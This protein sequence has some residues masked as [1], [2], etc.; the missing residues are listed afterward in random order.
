MNGRHWL[1]G[2]GVVLALLAGPLSAETAPARK[3]DNLISDQ[4]GDWR[5]RHVFDR[6]TLAHRYSDAKTEIRLDEGKTHPFQFNRRGVDGA[7][8]FEIP[9]WFD[10]VVIEADGQTF[11]ETQRGFH[12]FYGT[13]T[14]ELLAAV[15]RA[16][17]PIRITLRH[18]EQVYRGEIPARGSSAAL[19]WIRA[20]Q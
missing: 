1:A 18:G 6:E 5:V 2:W 10:E 7:L 15:A 4:F 11:R 19:R 12:T 8:T 17:A 3:P 13:A 16:Q 14:P 20:I 9:G